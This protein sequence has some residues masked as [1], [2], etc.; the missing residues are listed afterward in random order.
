L[1]GSLIGSDSLGSLKSISLLVILLHI[2]IIATLSIDADPTP[3]CS[4]LASERVFAAVLVIL[5]V[6]VVHC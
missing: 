2:G 5:V 1:E 4:N 3:A 6:V